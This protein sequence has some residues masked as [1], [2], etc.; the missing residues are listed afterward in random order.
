MVMQEIQTLHL[1]PKLSYGLVSLLGSLTIE[2]WL[3]PSPIEGRTVKDLASH[4]L[5]GSIKRLSLQ[6]D[7][8]FSD[9]PDVTT[10]TDLVGYI[11]QIN[12]EWIMASRRLSPKLLIE[13][14]KMVDRE[15]YEFFQGLDPNGK[16]LFPVAWAGET[17]SKN[18]FD[19]AREFTEKWH[20]QMQIRMS[21][22]KPLLMERSYVQPLYKTF[23]LGLPFALKEAR[24]FPDNTVVKVSISGNYVESWLVVKQNGQWGINNDD[25][26]PV[27]TEIIIPENVGWVIFTN[28]D[29]NKLQYVSQMNIS[30]NEVLAQYVI[31]MVTVMS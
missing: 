24:D 26:S 30:G 29:R 23:M 10:Y 15:V 28:T 25:L 31:N 16:A 27:K 21:L 9:K 22:G 19:L 12:K 13:L 8:F 5:D 17:E 4:I 2:E 1:F 6:R 11:Q 3:M 7:Q 14:M 18:W 20:H